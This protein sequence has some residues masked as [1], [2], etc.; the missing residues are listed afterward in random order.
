[1]NIHFNELY[2]VLLGMQDQIYVFCIWF[3]L[4][5]VLIFNLLQVYFMTVGFYGQFYSI[6]QMNVW[7]YKIFSDC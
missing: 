6:K 1:M 3:F 2:C 4:C 5:C 7:Q